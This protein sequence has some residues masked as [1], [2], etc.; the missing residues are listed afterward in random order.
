MFVHILIGPQNAKYIL[1]ADDEK[2]NVTQM[3]SVIHQMNRIFEE[4]SDLESVV[5]HMLHSTCYSQGISQG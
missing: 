4:N 2:K 3:G 5:A 1:K